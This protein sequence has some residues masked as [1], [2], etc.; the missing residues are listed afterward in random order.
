M[1]L[2]AVSCTLT[3]V[4]DLDILEDDDDAADGESLAEEDSDLQKL[5]L[6]RVSTV[7]GRFRTLSIRS[8]KLSI[9]SGSHV[10]KDVDVTEVRSR[11]HLV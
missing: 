5:R 10:G 3:D 4:R 8:S 9:S 11:L 6:S 2:N 7:S 1:T